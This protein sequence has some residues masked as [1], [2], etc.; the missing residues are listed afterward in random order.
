[1]RDNKSIYVTEEDLLQLRRLLTSKGR[2]EGHDKQYL[3]DLKDELDRAVVVP[4]KDM[5]HRVLTMDSRFL[6]KDLDT[7]DVAEYTLVSPGQADIRRGKLS[8]LAPIGTALLGYQESDTVE[9]HVPAGIKRFKIE[10]VLFQPE[11]AE[12]FVL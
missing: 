10:R 3:R 1:M 11:A 6:L 4:R 2:L 12:E 5:P 8:V 7:G 9:W